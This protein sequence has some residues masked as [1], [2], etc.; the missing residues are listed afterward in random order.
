MNRELR[1][2]AANYAR[3]LQDY[4]AGRGE[5]ALQAA[6]ELGR[7]TLARG[8]GMLDMVTIQHYALLKSMRKVGTAAEGSRALRGAHKLVVESLL[9]FEMSYRRSQEVNTALRESEQRYRDLVDTARDV[10]YTLSTEAKIASLNPVFETITGWSRAEWIGR[11]F[12]PLVHPDDLPRALE[13]YQAV[14]EGRVPSLFELRILSKSGAYIPGEFVATP[15]MQDTRIVGM[16]GIARDIT[17]RKRA[18]EALRRLN[19]ALE[20]EAKRIAHALHDE[21]GQL[22]A[23]VH[24]VLG[25]IARD[26][27]PHASRRLE[28]VTGLLTKIEEQLRHLSHELRPTILDDLGLRPALEFLADGVSRRTGLLI[29]VEGFKGKRLPAPIETV[30]YRVVQEAL[31]NASKH[32]QATRV[33]IRLAREGRFLRCAIRDDGAGFDVPA[34]LARQGTRGLGLVGIQER[35]SAVGGTLDID[36]TPGSG[37]ELIVSVPVEGSDGDSD[38]PGR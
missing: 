15:L 18:E 35:L 22:L 7:T 14:L 31:T 32:A 5:V 27:P 6:Y 28:D 1:E 11:A 8:L 10:I 19:E 34:V 3:A 36:S 24:I 2:L 23:S 20:D 37:A 9:P 29:S 26:L 25:E 17:D 21:A 33:A 13:L 30:V 16:L 12:A 38:S 4:V